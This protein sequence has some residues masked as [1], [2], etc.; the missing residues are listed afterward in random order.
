[1]GRTL[2][3]KMREDVS[4]VFLRT[5]HFAELFA[6]VSKSE[7]RKENIKAIKTEHGTGPDR[8]DHAETFVRRARF[9]IAESLADGILIPA[10][11]DTIE[12]ATGAAPI[13]W[14][15]AFNQNMKLVH[16]LWTLEFTSVGMSK[17]GQK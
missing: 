5:E 16:G 6:Y 15:L 9:Q 11:G 2:A 13:V 4:R 8:Q 14:S 3:S 10:R 12:D 1:M 17:Q 7:G